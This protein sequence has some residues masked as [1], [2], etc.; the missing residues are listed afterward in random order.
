M[1]RKPPRACCDTG[2]PA[3]LER[4]AVDL[5]EDRA[6]AEVLRADGDVRAVAGGS[7]VVGGVGAGGGFG[8]GGGLGAGRGLGAGGGLGVG[9]LVG[10]IALVAAAGGQRKSDRQ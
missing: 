7:G 6:L 9:G 8:A 1:S 10:G 4:L 5:G 3:L 2:Y